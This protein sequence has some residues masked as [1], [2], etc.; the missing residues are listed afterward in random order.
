MIKYLVK[1]WRA[2]IHIPVGILTPLMLLLH[3][4]LSV[5][6][7]V[8]FMAYE[9]NEDLHLKDKAYLDISGY[10]V[11]YCIGTGLMWLLR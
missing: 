2:F 10:L 9:L 4:V 6:F 11:G 8:G 5:L 3:P 1:L 7:F